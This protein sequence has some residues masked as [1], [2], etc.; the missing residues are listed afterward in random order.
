MGKIG[1]E[2]KLKFILKSI[3]IGIVYA[4]RIPP[5]PI[6]DRH[7]MASAGHFVHWIQEAL[8]NKYVCLR[9]KTDI[10]GHVFFPRIL[11]KSQK[12]LMKQW[13]EGRGSV[14][15]P[16]PQGQQDGR[17]DDE[18]DEPCQD[19]ATKAMSQKIVEPCAK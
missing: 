15:C 10:Q 1:I 13:L 4:F 18:L 16:A 6:G 7:Q 8:F 3:R 12:D 11:Y 5:R 9:K 2:S 14:I 19:D 17:V